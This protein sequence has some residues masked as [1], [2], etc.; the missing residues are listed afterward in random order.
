LVLL[1][2]FEEEE[3][4]E[5]I[6]LGNA[7]MRCIKVADQIRVVILEEVVPLRVLMNINGVAFVRLLLTAMISNKEILHGA[8]QGNAEEDIC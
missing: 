3:Q 5:I 6:H 7:R 2:I 4:G 8:I 1:L